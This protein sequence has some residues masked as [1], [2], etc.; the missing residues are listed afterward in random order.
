MLPARE[1]PLRLC[2]DRSGSFRRMV[3]G[4][5][6]P[7]KAEDVPMGEN[8]WENELLNEVGGCDAVGL[9]TSVDIAFWA[10]AGGSEDEGREYCG[11]EEPD[12]IDA[13][14]CVVL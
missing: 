9:Y 3:P 2:A 4:A 13:V 12:E 10:V 8:G 11:G 7:S 6:P 14:R 1:K 5:A